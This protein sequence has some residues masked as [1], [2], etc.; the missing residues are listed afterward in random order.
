MGGV[1]ETGA[2]VIIRQMKEVGLVA[3]RT[4][5]MRPDGLLEEELPKGA[6]CKAVQA[7]DMRITL[8]G[9]PFEKMRGVGAKTYEPYKTKYGKEPTSYALYAAE[10]GRVIVDAIKRAAPQIEKAK[11][12]TEKREAVRKAIAAT[13]NFEGINGKWS[14]DEN[15]DVVYVTNAGFK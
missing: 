10:G 14:F 13:K 12:V 6:T 11:D 4:S 3:P 9:L 2:Q 1:I 8:D 15:G 5:F 7:T